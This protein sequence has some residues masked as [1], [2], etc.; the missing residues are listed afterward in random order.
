MTESAG[1]PRS[2]QTRRA[3]LSAAYQSLSE[4]GFRSVTMDDI[5]HR[6]GASKATLYRWWPSKAAILLDAVHERSEAYPEFSDS[7]DAR[8]DLRNEIRGV[9]AFYGTDA[10]TAT[11]DLVA[12]SRFDPSLAADFRERFIMGRRKAT[13][14]VFGRGIARDQ[15]R[16]DLNFD[17]VMDA[18]WGAL[19]YKLLISNTL[20][21]ADYADDLIDAFWGA[22]AACPHALT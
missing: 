3:V 5:A 9:I 17:V 21:H 1:R 20:L 6:A 2:E 14:E 19:Y 15:I 8:T 22:I 16:G 12:E 10:G 7:G 18:L 13:A 11:L 4:V